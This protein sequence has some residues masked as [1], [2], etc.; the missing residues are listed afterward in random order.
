MDTDILGSTMML[1]LHIPLMTKNMLRDA[2]TLRDRYDDMV[3]DGEKAA[4]KAVESSTMARTA[5]GQKLLDLAALVKG[6]S[7][8]PTESCIESTTTTISNMSKRVTGK[9]EISHRLA[10]ILTYDKEAQSDYNSLVATLNRIL[11]RDAQKEEEKKSLQLFIS[12]QSE[13]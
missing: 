2:T 3:E 1:P 11:A 6:E 8:P 4:S 10:G 9:E 13:L 12:S 5:W 7:L